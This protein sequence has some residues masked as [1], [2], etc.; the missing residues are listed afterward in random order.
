MKP[1]KLLVIPFIA[2]L[3]LAGLVAIAAEPAAPAV[4]AGPPGGPPQGPRNLMIKADDA[5][6]Q[7]RTYHFDATN[8]EMPYSVF[9]SSKVDKK[10]PAPL[11]VTLHGL[12]MGPGIMMRAKALELAEA[13]GYILVAPMGYNI[14]GWYGSPVINMQ[15]DKP[16]EP[17]NLAELSEQDVMNVLGIVRKEFNVDPKRTYLMGHSMGGAGTL[18][19]GSKHKNEWAAIAALAPAAFLLQPNIPAILDPLKDK[20]IMIVQGD[21]DTL[22][23][24]Q[25]THAWVDYLKDHKMNYQY[26]E[27]PGADHG[28]VIDQGLPDIYAFFAKQTRK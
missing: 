21:K 18:F 5:R 14:G 15:R 9:V 8:E 7:N 25:N 27:I 13:G 16:V 23:P 10:K 24:P 11:I 28:S 2:A 19:L 26:I 3:G 6:V 22:V 4:P 17:A 20:P 12:G 1:L